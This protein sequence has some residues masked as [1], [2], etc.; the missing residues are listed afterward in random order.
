MIFSGQSSIVVSLGTTLVGGNFSLKFL[1]GG[2]L[3]GKLLRLHDE[4]GSF[5]AQGWFSD[6]MNI[7]RNLVMLCMHASVYMHD[8]LEWMCYVYDMLL[9]SMCNVNACFEKCVVDA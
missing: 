3:L 9:A 8:L 6:F 7:T 5:W 4:M 2:Y 1:R